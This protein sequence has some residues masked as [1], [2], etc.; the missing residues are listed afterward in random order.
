M[1]AIVVG[2]DGWPGCGGLL[3][4]LRADLAVEGARA[5][6]EAIGRIDAPMVIVRSHGE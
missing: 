6:D 4:Q 1:G 5:L 2:V 3:P